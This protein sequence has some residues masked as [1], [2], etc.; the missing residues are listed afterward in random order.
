MM[1][2]LMQTLL[3]SAGPELAML[4]V[5]YWVTQKR[6]ER[7]EKRLEAK[8]D[9]VQRFCTRTLLKLATTNRRTIDRNTRA[10]ERLELVVAD[11]LDA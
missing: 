10:L 3:T 1:P 9:G 7:R 6:E 8:L 11:D 5:F 2:E 4:A